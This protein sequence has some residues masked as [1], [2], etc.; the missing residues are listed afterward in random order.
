MCWAYGCFLNDSAC[1]FSYV[2]LVV[3]VLLFFVICVSIYA[4]YRIFITVS[5]I[6]FS[7]DCCRRCGRRCCRCFVSY[8]FYFSF[9][10]SY[11]FYTF[12]WIHHSAFFFIHVKRFRLRWCLCSIYTFS[13]F[14]KKCLSSFSLL[15]RFFP[16]RRKMNHKWQRGR[17]RDRNKKSTEKLLYVSFTF[18]AEWI[19]ICSCL[20]SKAAANSVKAM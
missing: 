19:S 12:T 16:T 20:R 3:C 4:I 9:V 10:R 7:S 13:S 18:C 11:I 6:L 8:S 17:E 15:F 5:F 1:F 14:R 2:S